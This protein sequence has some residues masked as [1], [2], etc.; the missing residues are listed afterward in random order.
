[1]LI[2]DAVFT[3]GIRDGVTRSEYIYQYRELLLGP[4]DPQT[5]ITISE[6]A[7]VYTMSYAKEH[8]IWPVVPATPPPLQFCRPREAARVAAR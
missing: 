6:D 4:G 5:S 3:K 1:M 7:F 2:G 8:G